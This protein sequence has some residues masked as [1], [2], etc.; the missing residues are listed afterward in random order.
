ME[1][2]E[3]LKE[4]MMF[5]SL[6]KYQKLNPFTKEAYIIKFGNSPAQIIVSKEAFMKRAEANPNF[7]G[8]KAGCI[9]TNVDDIDPRYTQGAFILPD[10]TLVGGWAEVYR[11]DRKIPTRIEIS[12]K[13]FNKGQ[14]TWKTMPATMIR[15]TAIVNALREAFP[16]DLGAMQTE[17]DKKVEDETP[18]SVA[19]NINELTGSKQEAQEPVKEPA[20][21]PAKKT[22]KVKKSIKD[23]TPKSQPIPQD[24]LPKTS[25]R[26]SADEAKKAYEEIKNGGI[27]DDAETDKQ[28]EQTEADGQTDLFDGE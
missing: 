21:E 8:F 18:K 17:D 19:T 23:V 1:T 9:A 10:E 6:C 16:N 26:M 13:E 7:D 4:T 25:K 12:L 28:P 11:K 20:K 14:S 24:E 27:D 5:L 2:Q 15:K 3:L 22:A